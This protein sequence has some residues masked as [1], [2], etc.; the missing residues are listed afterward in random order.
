[1]SKEFKL[2]LSILG[3]AAL[4]G[5]VVFVGW[6]KFLQPLWEHNAQIAKLDD[7]LIDARFKLE[8]VKKK[9]SELETYRLQSLPVNPNAALTDYRRW[10]GGFLTDNNMLV[11]YLQGRPQF[12]SNRLTR[13]R[14]GQKKQEKPVYQPVHFEVRGRIRLNDFVRLMQRLQRVPLMHRI[15]TMHVEPL[16]RKN[17]RPDNLRVNMTIEALMVEG[18]EVRPET[19]VGVDERLVQLDVL[20]ALRQGPTGIALIPWVVG[21]TGPIAERQL[22]MLM[23][24]L[25]YGKIA[26]KNVFEGY[27]K[28]IIDDPEP[29]PPPDYGPDQRRFARLTRIVRGKVR[30]EAF[31]YNPYLDKAIRMRESRL[32]GNF[33]IRDESG[34]KIWVEGKVRRIDAREVF[35][36]VDGD[37]YRLELGQTVA[38]AMRRRLDDSELLKLNL[39]PEGEAP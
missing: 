6:T 32:F 11:D 39:L 23:P 19:L 30:H 21:P 35:F 18:A 1:M 9:R 37:V 20:A 4:F 12:R 33:D 28:T 8:H 2:T 10:L 38:D 14:L 31:I 16:D 5:A 17:G 36:E 27:K 24:K 22:A 3:V 29:E 15:R 13:T 34:E 7:D 25:D 26:K